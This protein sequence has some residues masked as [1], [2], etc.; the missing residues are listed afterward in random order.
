[1]N[2]LSLRSRKIK[3]TTIDTKEIPKNVIENFLESNTMGKDIAKGC[4]LNES[5]TE[6]KKQIQQDHLVG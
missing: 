1:M 5:I 3:D 4:H 2:R 6:E